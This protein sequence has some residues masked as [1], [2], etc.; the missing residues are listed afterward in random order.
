MRERTSSSV[1]GWLR[2]HSLLLLGACLAGCM[3]R[4]DGQLPPPVTVAAL[5]ARPRDLPLALEYPAQLRGVREVEVRARVSGI[6]LERHYREGARVARGD[7]LF[8]IDPEPFRAEAARARAEL[9]VQRVSLD[10]AR[11]ERDR[12]LPLY[13]KRLAS[14]S[15]RDAAVAAYESAAAAVAVAEAALRKAELDLSYTQV[16]AP[17][18]GL[19][20]REARSEGSL[21]TAGD[22][23]A[24]L[25]YIVQSDSLYVEFGVSG[26]DAERLHEALEDASDGDPVVRVVD[27]AGR[28]TGGVAKIEFIAPRMD[29]ATGTVDVRAVLDN[30]DGALLPGRIVRARLEG[31]VLRRALVVPKRALVHG[32]EGP[33]LWLIGAGEKVAPRPVEVGISAGNEVTIARGLA[34][35]ERVVVD[36]ILKVQPGAVVH[37]TPVSSAGDAPGAPAPPSSTAGP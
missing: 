11:R 27:A 22:D 15:E 13:D 21:V 34:A 36:G 33:F 6:L 25:T 23:S 18:A 28:Q 19:T 5:E 16:R 37:A 31:I 7:L 20:S 30:R 12:V 35:G 1:S 14:H 10:Q 2:A 9:G 32:A 17:I 8:S 4:S 26:A 24:L 3:P 29:P